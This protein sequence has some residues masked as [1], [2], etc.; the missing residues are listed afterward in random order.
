MKIKEV[1][2]IFNFS[3]IIN[4]RKQIDEIVEPPLVDVCKYL[5]DINIP[6]TMSSVN[7]QKGHK[8][9][10]ITIDYDLLSNEN[11]NIVNKLV[12]SHPENVVIGQFS[13]LHEHNEVN[14]MLPIEDETD[15]VYVQNYFWKF[16]RLF[17]IQ[18]IQSFL[19]ADTFIKNVYTISDILYRYL[20]CEKDDFAKTKFTELKEIE[21]FLLSM[22]YKKVRTSEFNDGKTIYNGHCEYLWIDND[23]DRTWM[24]DYH[25]YSAILKNKESL[26]GGRNIKKENLN[27]DEILRVLNRQAQLYYGEQFFFNPEDKRF[28]LNEE[29]LAKHNRYIQSQQENILEGDALS[30]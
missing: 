11:K 30:K 17:K 26:F 7:T 4:H 23:I 19:D 2:S 1:D 29:L 15:I 8:K 25:I 24:P 5:Y 13:T 18:D 10:Y 6:T 9:A 28:Y 21:D 12:L 27:F 3:N 20:Y 22:G 16:A 14:I